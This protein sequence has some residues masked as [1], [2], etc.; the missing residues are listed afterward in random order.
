MANIWDKGSCRFD[1]K[2]DK[3]AVEGNEN[4]WG[5]RVMNSKSAITVKWWGRRWKRKRNGLFAVIWISSNHLVQLPVNISL[6]YLL[7][8]VLV[9][10]LQW[11]E[12]PEPCSC[13]FCLWAAICVLFL[14]F[15][16]TKRKIPP[17]QIKQGCNFYNKDLKLLSFNK[18]V[19]FL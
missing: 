7:L 12:I 18:K 2:S 5:E 15:P 11:S 1:N 4:W 19:L 9:M 16:K 8:H 13:L 14:I 6:L 17:I 10:S 3:E